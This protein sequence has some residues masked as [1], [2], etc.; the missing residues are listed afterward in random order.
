VFLR[1][2]PELDLQVEVTVEGVVIARVDAFDFD[3]NT[4]HEVD[5]RI[6]HEGDDGRDVLWQEKLRQD[7]I[8]PAWARRRAVGVGATRAATCHRGRDAGR[9]AR[10]LGVAAF[11]LIAAGSGS[12]GGRHRRRATASLGHPGLHHRARRAITRRRRLV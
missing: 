4:A 12:L 3:G 1:E 9:L 7:A 8:H 5:G 6:K 2:G 10:R 11:V